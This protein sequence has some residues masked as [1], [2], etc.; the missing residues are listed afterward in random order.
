[1]ADFERIERLLALI[2]I[3]QMVEASEQEKKLLNRKLAFQIVR[4]QVSLEKV[5]MQ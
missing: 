4:Y 2:L 1:V 5:L 3:N